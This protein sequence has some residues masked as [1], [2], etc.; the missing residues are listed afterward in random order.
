MPS[1]E[2]STKEFEGRDWEELYC[3]YRDVSKATGAKKPSESQKA[4]ALWSMKAAKDREE[5]FYD[6]ARK[7]DILEEKRHDWSCG[8]RTSKTQFLPW[9]KR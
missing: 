4:K 2:Q 1:A 6:P 5:E 7:E 3:H 8:K 9:P